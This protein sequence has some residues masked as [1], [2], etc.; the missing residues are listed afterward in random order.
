[1]TVWLPEGRCVIILATLSSISLCYTCNGKNGKFF[2]LAPSPSLP[3][4]PNFHHSF[5]YAY[6]TI[7]QIPAARLVVTL[8]IHIALPAVALGTP[9]IFVVSGRDP[10]N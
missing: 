5:Q 3:F 4:P 6:G 2:A 8:R 7:L 9:V 10:H 1:M